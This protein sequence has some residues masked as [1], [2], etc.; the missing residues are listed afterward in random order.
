[1]TVRCRYISRVS[2]SRKCTRSRDV[3][4]GFA[5]MRHRLTRTSRGTYNWCL[6]LAQGYSSYGR[7]D[8]SPYNSQCIVFNCTHLWYFMAWVWTQDGSS[9]GLKVVYRS[10]TRNTQIGVEL[11][12]HAHVSFCHFKGFQYFF[13][14]VEDSERPR[15]KL[16]EY[17]TRLKK[18]WKFNNLSPKNR[19]VVDELLA[20]L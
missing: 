5:Q 14:R 13:D 17:S 11:F 9:S 1:M 19:W 3:A 4:R 2:G 12:Y 8:V 6:E 7:V 16:S 15:P 10:D 18:Y 20:T